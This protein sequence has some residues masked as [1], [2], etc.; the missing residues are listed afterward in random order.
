MP[1]AAIFSTLKILHELT[2]IY[3]Y[4]LLKNKLVSEVFHPT[5][6]SETGVAADT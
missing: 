3:I 5:W 4:Y 1:F 2:I 6:N